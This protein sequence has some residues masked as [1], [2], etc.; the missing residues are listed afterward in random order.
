MKS[1]EALTD[2][3]AN[4]F[5]MDVQ[6]K[7]LDGVQMNSNYPTTFE[8]P[9]NKDKL[10]V[11]VGKYV[12]VGFHYSKCTER[13]WVIVDENGGKEGTWYGILDNDPARIPPDVLKYEDRVCFQAKHILKTNLPPMPAKRF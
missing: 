1:P 3:P 9:S 5:A 6:Y 10:A 12:Q 13:M 7:L 4:S 2:I 8:I 11:E